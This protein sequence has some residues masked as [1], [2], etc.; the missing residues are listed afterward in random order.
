MS[1]IWNAFA[2]FNVNGITNLLFA[3]KSNW[4]FLL[5]SAGAVCSMIL[6]LKEEIETT[7]TQEQQVL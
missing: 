3:I 5:I 4:W 7:V 2:A 6:S 1:A